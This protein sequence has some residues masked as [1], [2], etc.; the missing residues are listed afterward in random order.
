MPQG[1]SKIENARSFIVDVS[2]VY[3]EFPKKE[4]I[5]YD[6]FRKAVSGKKDSAT[7]EIREFVHETD[8]C[9]VCPQRRQAI[10]HVTQLIGQL[11]E[12]NQSLMD[13]LTD[14][15]KETETNVDP[16]FGRTRLNELA[17]LVESIANGSDTPE[18]QVAKTMKKICL[19]G[20]HVYLKNTVND[21]FERWCTQPIP[22]DTLLWNSD[23]KENV[24]RGRAPTE[25][26][27]VIHQLQPTAVFGIC[28]QYW[29]KVYECNGKINVTVLTDVGQN[30][31]RCH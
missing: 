19:L 12:E 14:V 5:G 4:E 27:Q 25:D 17:D 13:T 20:F 1:H 2:K 21:L 24:K 28:I 18:K 15:V 6:A 30:L 22:V 11:P 26:S 16:D 29:N 31:R 7:P 3:R 23:W 8:L 9:S 10:R